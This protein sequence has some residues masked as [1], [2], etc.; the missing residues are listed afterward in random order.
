[1]HDSVQC[2]SLGRQTDFT[3]VVI[4]IKDNLYGTHTYPL[5]QLHES[6]AVAR[7]ASSAAKGPQG[8]ANP[9]LLLS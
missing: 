6:P 9:K 4:T 7:R 1:M 8:Y 2:V 3:P 5:N